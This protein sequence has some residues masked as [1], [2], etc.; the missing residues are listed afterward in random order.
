MAVAEHEDDIDQTKA[1]LLDHLIELRL[2]FDLCLMPSAPLSLFRVH[3][4]SDRIYKFLLVPFKLGVGGK[5]PYKTD[6]YCA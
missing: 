1:P 4:F 5:S 6:L 2:R 3:I